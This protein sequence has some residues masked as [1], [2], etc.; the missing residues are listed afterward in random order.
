MALS[1]DGSQ[2][3]SVG[4]DKVIAI[5]DTE[6]NAIKSKLDAGVK[7]HAMGIY[8]V[9]WYDNEHIVTC[10][11]DNNVHIW[12]INGGEIDKTAVHRLF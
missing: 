11:A 12:K 7:A 10:S 6:T 8:D 3:A 1:P 2:Y 5:Y 9:S 4:A